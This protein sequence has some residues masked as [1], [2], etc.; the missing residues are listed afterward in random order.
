MIQAWNNQICSKNVT[1]DLLKRLPATVDK[2]ARRTP[3]LKGPK[4]NDYQANVLYLV[5]QFACDALISCERQLNVMDG[6]SG[7]ADTGSKMRQG[8]E[9]ILRELGLKRLKTT[10]PFTFLEYLSRLST[11][12][13]IC[14]CNR[15]IIMDSEK[16]A[17]IYLLTH[18]FTCTC[19]CYV[20]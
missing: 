19:V 2:F 15:V 5:T 13:V 12:L 1:L 17:I 4:I 14:D 18:S 9:A 3:T 11:V 8:A 6:E 16:N 10:H 20:Y 7:D